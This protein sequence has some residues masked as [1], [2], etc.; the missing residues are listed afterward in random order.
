MK[1]RSSLL[2]IASLAACVLNFAA[3]QNN[4]DTVSSKILALERQW[5]TAYKGSD[6]AGMNSLLAEDFIIT[7][8]DGSTFSKSGYI[9]RNGDSS[10]HVWISEMSDL[11]FVPTVR[12]SIGS[13]ASNLGYCL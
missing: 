13:A 1:I 6:I 9:A 2:V 11:A 12:N 7:V 5:N 3:A 8:E 10:V 4:P